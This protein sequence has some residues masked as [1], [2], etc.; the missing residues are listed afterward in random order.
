MLVAPSNGNNEQIDK[1]SQAME[2]E[3]TG[4]AI[5]PRLIAQEARRRP[6]RTTMTIGE[7]TTNMA[8]TRTSSSQTKKSEA[9]DP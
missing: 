8:R 1:I 9:T 4:Q 3:D 5:V 7:K 2:D 6:A